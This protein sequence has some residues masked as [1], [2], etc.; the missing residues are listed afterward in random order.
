MLQRVRAG[1]EAQAS[2]PAIAISGAMLNQKAGKL[3][4]SAIAR[5]QL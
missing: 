4:L 1:V 3:L 5:S 2:T